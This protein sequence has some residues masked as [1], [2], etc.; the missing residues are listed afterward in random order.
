METV[1]DL[2][3]KA[4]ILIERMLT[5]YKA[6]YESQKDTDTH[7]RYLQ[8]Q[9]HKITDILSDIMIRHYNISDDQ[10]LFS[11]LV[12]KKFDSV[13]ALTTMPTKMSEYAEHTETLPLVV[14]NCA[15]CAKEA[16]M[17]AMLTLNTSTQYIVD[18]DI[19]VVTEP[20]M[21][22]NCITYIVIDGKCCHI[23]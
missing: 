19:F 20:V 17:Q 7:N 8:Y 6:L 2:L 4:K 12:Y 16:Y 14:T 13:K 5:N 10:R 21:R 11:V 18:G 9:T 23:F 3:I 15:N 1:P 22:T